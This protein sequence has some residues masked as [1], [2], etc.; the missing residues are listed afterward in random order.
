MQLIGETLVVQSAHRATITLAA[1]TTFRHQDP[2]S[3][4]LATIH[5]LK[6]LSFST[7]RSEHVTDYQALF[8]RID[9]RL[10]DIAT[11]QAAQTRPVS[12]L[13]DE[14]RAGK[15]HIWLI[16]LY[17]LYGRYLLISSSRPGPK[18][19][20][21]NL[22]G[23]WNEQMAPTWGS[24]FTI[25]VNL[26]M[27]Y[28]HAGTTALSECQLPLFDL[29]ERLALN[30]ALTAQQMYGCRGWCAHHNTDI[31]AD[32]APQDRVI[33]ATLWPM[34]G[35]WLCTHIWSHFEFTGDVAT[36][37]R[38][39][40]VLKGCVEFFLDFLVERNGYKVTSPSLSPE[41]RYRLPNGEEGTMCIGPTMDSEIL[42][43]LLSN[44]LAA[45]RALRKHDD[46]PMTNEVDQ[47]L[48]KLP[49]LRVGQHG[50]LQEWWEDHEE[51]EPGHRHVSHLWGLY[52]GEQ[53]T[54]SNSAL[55]NACK[56]TLRR[57][58]AHGGGHTG[59]SRAWMIALWARLGDGEEAG[60]HVIEILRTSTHDSLLD[61]HPPFQI[62]G[63][64][65]ATAGITEML[66][67]SH[68]GNIQLLPA[69]PSSWP[70]GSVQGLCARGGF[71]VDLEWASGV[72]VICKIRSSLGKDCTVRYNRS[73]TVT[74]N[75]REVISP[76]AMQGPGVSFRTAS[77]CEYIIRQR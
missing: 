34:G 17:Y 54:Q 7:L 73:I 71:A 59:W 62:D 2:Q 15:P 13:M 65:G 76:S 21:A 48:G 25:N 28:W 35:A 4:C 75:G 42:F 27:N 56:A 70:D 30:G 14:A 39:Y 33:T 23:I 6:K 58:A 36:L 67:Q 22:Q 69:L 44:Y 47:M 26:E 29:M 52:P 45:T 55:L 9:L 72:L 50:Q 43:Q 46:D 8:C 3:A 31:W 40:P 16:N 32:S 74:C 68:G 19:L 53:I 37:E 57:R 18:S 12:R 24:K 60:K 11:R 20:P 10:G 41:N 49:P 77:G 63:N 1:E 64:F 5:E 51:V 66:M 61:D 38:M